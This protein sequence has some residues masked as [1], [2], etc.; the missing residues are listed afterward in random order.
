MLVDKPGSQYLSGTAD[1]GLT[2]G[3]YR[4]PILL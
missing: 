2:M 1:T 3:D 4:L